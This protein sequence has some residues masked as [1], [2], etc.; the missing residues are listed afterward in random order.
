MDEIQ[1]GRPEADSEDAMLASPA[2]DWGDD[3]VHESI[4]LTRPGIDFRLPGRLAH[5]R[6]VPWEFDDFN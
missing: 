2:R 6:Q 3:W 1:P 5:E 4:A